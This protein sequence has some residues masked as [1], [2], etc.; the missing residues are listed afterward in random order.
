MSEQ[1]H[2]LFWA[3][4][5][6][7]KTRSIFRTNYRVNEILNCPARRGRRGSW[8]IALEGPPVK[9]MSGSG[10]THFGEVDETSS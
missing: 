9:R 5:G 7:K 8:I 10:E 1:K 3:G 4:L 2:R 6:R